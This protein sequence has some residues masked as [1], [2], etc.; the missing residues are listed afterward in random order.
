MHRSLFDL[1]TCPRCRDP[2]QL[3]ASAETETDGEIVSGR[4]TC[5]GCR[6]DYPIR[7]GVPRFVEPED[8][9]CGNFGFQWNT[10]K[11]LQID[12]LAG[13]SLSETRFL[14]DSRWSPEWLDGKLI[15]DA[16][17]G[18]GRFADVAA[19]FG[20]RVVAVDISSAIDACHETTTVHGNGVACLQASLFNLPLRRGMFD[21]V[22]CMGVIQHTPDPVGLMAALPGHLKPGGRLAY[23]FYEEGVWRR[24]QV[25]K[26]G[27]R[28]ITPHLSVP[29]TLALSKFLVAVFFPLTGLLSRVRKL[30]I[31]NHF[32]P[33]A[34]I[35]DPALSR[36]QQY[37]WTLLDTFDWYGARYEKR[38]DHRRAMALLRDAGLEEVEGRAGLV[39]GRAK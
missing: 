38:Q 3:G 32:L 6:T 22:Y 12:R 18:A 5:P 21:A 17:C 8:D 10:W 27:L 7:D 37:A 24:L 31:L 4:L 35:H 1:L 2:R 13:H 26:Y 15:L 16:G 36:E 39:W 29:T 9:Y 23:N 14:A 20:A 34:A 30:R 25:I 28:L 19:G 11:T 33:I